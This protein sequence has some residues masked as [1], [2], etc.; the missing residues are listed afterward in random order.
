[1]DVPVLTGGEG[2]WSESLRNCIRQIE[3]DQILLVLED[4]FL[5]SKIDPAKIIS[6][7]KFARENADVLYLS[8]RG[9]HKTENIL[10]QNYKKLR[11]DAPYAISLQPA[12]WNRKCLLSLLENNWSPWQ[13]EIKGSRVASELDLSIWKV[14][15]NPL[16]YEGW[17]THH[18]VEKGEWIPHEW[19]LAR[20]RGLPVDRRRPRMSPGTYIKYIAREKANYLGNA[21]FGTAW[22]SVRRSITKSAI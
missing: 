19:W 4:F 14:I 13:F 17:I 22:T 5:R 20:R 7:I 12:I 15:K 3:T 1:M 6:A 2:S 21:I 10:D 16:N 18:V 11:T 8:T 9:R